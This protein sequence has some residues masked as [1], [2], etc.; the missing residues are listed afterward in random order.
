MHGNA[1]NDTYVVDSIGDVVS[2]QTVS[3][4]DDGG[5]DTVIAAIDYTLGAYVENLT[6]AGHDDLD[7]TGNGLDNVLIGNDGDN[8]LTG[9]AGK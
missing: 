5:T 3:G 2:E 4:V 8:S 6:L 9:G 7:G 1:G